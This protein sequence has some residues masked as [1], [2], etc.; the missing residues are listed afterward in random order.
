LD[1]FAC[2]I[3]KHQSTVWIDLRRTH[4]DDYIGQT[5]GRNAAATEKGE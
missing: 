4:G 1:A 2:A 3:V 5:A